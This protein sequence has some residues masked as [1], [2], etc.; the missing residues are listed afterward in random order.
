MMKN[1][2]GLRQTS[3]NWKS[4]LWKIVDLELP[5]SLSDLQKRFGVS[6][7]EAFQWYMEVRRRGRAKRSSAMR[8]KKALREIEQE[9]NDN[10]ADTGCTASSK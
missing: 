2:G 1:L 9:I 4:K 10:Y 8:T 6:Q 5:H 7:Q 3:S